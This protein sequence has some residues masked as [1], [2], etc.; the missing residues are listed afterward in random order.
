MQ[1]FGR[2]EIPMQWIRQK[3]TLENQNISWDVV[4]Y[5]DLTTTEYVI[6]IASKN[7]D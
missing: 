6:D 5:D 1:Y 7:N 2:I 3:L 4:T